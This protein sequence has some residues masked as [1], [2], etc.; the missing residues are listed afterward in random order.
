[1]LIKLN[2]DP[3]TRAE[4]IIYMTCY[5]FLQYS[6]YLS[7]QSLCKLCTILYTCIYIHKCYLTQDPS[8]QHR[9]LGALASGN[10]PLWV[11]KEGVELLLMH[12]HLNQV[13]V[14]V[15]LMQQ[16]EN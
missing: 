9:Y 6:S 2:A 15:V 3:S 14:V 1:M 7:F 12:Q 11:N 10:H 8:Q 13:I 4:V 16:L 5:I